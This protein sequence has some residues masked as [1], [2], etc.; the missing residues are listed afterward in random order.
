MTE[1]RGAGPGG[2]GDRRSSRSANSRP[3]RQRAAASTQARTAAGQR[4]G[5]RRTSSS[6]A[7]SGVA[8]K[9][10]APRSTGRSRSPRAREAKPKREHRILGL[11]T[12]R[13]VVLAAVLCAL[14]LTL[15]VPTRTYLSQR[16]EATQLAQQR[17]D[18][19][20]D[21]AQL[22]ERRAQ[23]QDPNYIK[24]EARD[25][26][27]LVMPGDT[28]YIVQVPGIEQPAVPTPT[29]APRRPDPWYTQLYRSMDNPQPAAAPAT[30]APPPPPTP[31][32]PH[33]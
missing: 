16:A 32:G 21:V 5:Q 2:R 15:A 30:T 17:R 3:E 31:E 9:K 33:R 29:A 27:R 7:E 10:S 12:G 18:L 23:Q 24:S 8:E 14:A 11:S 25:R 28:A 1:R 22:R 13:A 26:L 4:A 20:A 19:E 6:K